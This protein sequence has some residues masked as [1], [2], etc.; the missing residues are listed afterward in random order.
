[1][2]S[3]AMS[4]PSKVR[5]TDH[6][7]SLQE[8]KKPPLVGKA[9]AVVNSNSQSSDVMETPV[10]KSAKEAIADD[11]TVVKDN[12]N[13][14]SV[15]NRLPSSSERRREKQERLAND[16][17]G[18]A[19]DNLLI[20]YHRQKL[21]PEARA[22]MEALGID[23][24]LSPTT[25]ICA[26]L[27]KVEATNKRQIDRLKLRPEALAKLEA[28]GINPETTPNTAVCA[29]LDKVEAMNKRKVGPDDDAVE[30]LSQHL[31]ATLGD[32]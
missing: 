12:L 14:L 6:L 22:R 17:P 1:M 9:A 13:G 25:A 23:P 30:G 18:T 10:C 21:R 32:N 11:V 15:G 28:A 31:R 16:S 29:I 26:S 3:S 24:G 8:T 5:G 19:F 27:D 4:T 7:P 20:D 2:S